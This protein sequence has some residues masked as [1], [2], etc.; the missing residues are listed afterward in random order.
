MIYGA[1]EGLNRL[2]DGH[3]KLWN[4]LWEGDIMIE[5]MTRRSV[6]CGLHFIIFTL[7]H[8]REAG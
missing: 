6:P 3:R 1:K 4:E 5:E 7:M 2:M 8:A